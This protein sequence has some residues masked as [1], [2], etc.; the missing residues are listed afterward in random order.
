[1]ISN[2]H[3]IE[4][5]INGK[6]VELESQR[7]LGLRINNVMFDPTKTSTTQAEYSFSFDIPSTPNN[8]KVLEYANNLSKA[9]KF[10]AR[11]PAQVYADGDLI[12]D[13]SL[14][15]QK[16]DSKEGMYTCNL[17]N[18]KINTLDEIFGDMA[19][20]DL[21]WMVDFDGAPTINQVNAS[22][23]TKYF[24]P[25]VCYGAFQKTYIE[26]DE[27]GATYTPKHTFDKYNKWWVQTF[28]PSLNMI[29]QMKIAFE[30]KG[31]SVGG[32]A[33]ADPYINQIYCSTNLAEEQV[34]TYNLGNPK[35]GKV[36]ITV[37]WNNTKS[38]VNKKSNFTGRRNFQNAT[39]AYNQDLTFPYEVVKPA[40]NSNNRDAEPQYNFSEIQWWNM[41]DSTNN[42]SG[43][44]VT[45]NQPTY[46][47]DPNEHLIVIP[48]DGWYKIY[49]SCT[50]T[51]NG[52]GSTFSANQWTN[53]FYEDDEFKER[54]IEVKR[55]FQNNGRTPFEVQL[56]RNYDDNIE[57]IKGKKNVRWDTGNPN[58]ETY[59][60]KGGSYTGSTVI[61][62]HEWKTDAPH[63]DPY[64][65]ISPTIMDNMIN[66]AFGAR[67]DVL[68][69]YG[70]E[71]DL[72]K[73]G[74]SSSADTSGATM[75]G[76]GSIT[77]SGRR[78][79]PITRGGTIDRT[80]GGRNSDYG[81]IRNGGYRG[82]T[83]FN[84]YGFMH[85]D[86]EIMPYDQA[87]STAFICGMSTM[88]DGTLGV[89]RDD[90]SWS[91][92][93]SVRNGVF[94]QV[95]GLDLVNIIDDSGGTETFNT[96]YCKNTYKDSDY[97][98]L[99]SNG[100]MNGHIECCVY[101]N[102]N[103]I[104]E[105]VGVQRAYDSD[106]F[107]SVNATCNLVITAMSDKRKSDLLSDPTWGYRS[108]TQLPTQLNLFNFTNKE[109]K[110][111]DWIKNVQT[112]F[113]F[114]ILQEGNSV[115]INTNKG[116]NKKVDYAVS[117]DD[118]VSEN[119]AIAEYISY[120][121]EMSVRYKINTEEW[122]FE[123]TV[124]EEHIND[125][126]WKEWGDSGFTIIQLNDDTYESKTQNTSTQFSYT[127][128]DNFLWKEVTSSGTETDFSGLTVA[129]PVISKAEYMAEGYGYEEA[130]KHDGYSL[131]QRFWYRDEVSDQY[132][133]LSDHM[134]EQV[135]LTYPINRWE[136]FNLSYKDIEKSIVTEYFNI[137]PLLSSNYVKIDVHLT[138]EEYNSIKCGALVN[139]DSDLYYTSEISGYDPSGDNPTT[140]KLIKKV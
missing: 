118:R 15:V 60:I 88:S 62:K 67:N 58:Q 5:H 94:A 16:Y 1:M 135:Y 70:Y 13:G 103:D 120:P 90:L 21:K 64:A 28:Y 36:D 139:Y 138:P 40:I 33:L 98:L 73:G 49:L 18:I 102:R 137:C 107:Y 134:H 51:L 122:G 48:A 45:V 29:E 86:N 127:Y 72:Y 7:S 57:L 136:R 111:G 115:D 50:A 78:V 133:Y 56:I 35:F 32:S 116:I 37:S 3:Y 59:T 109:T 10:H 69:A 95:K 96:N 112:A 75:D 93:S 41:M 2:T 24:F 46:L 84:T 71:N 121:R 38:A 123:L 91:K 81:T 55:G 132:V 130:M 89:M 129:I 4:L 31:Y 114:E 87:V 110:V 105:L 119:E 22:A 12:F 42:P 66:Q 140:L 79:P 126:D 125:E 6:Q 108:N 99:V 54:E 27:V 52:A 23:D 17:V 34:P 92:M 106:Q 47:Y 25:L 63:Q 26:K 104:L 43:V 128:Y 101:L 76:N 68:L 80:G 117:V 11:Y 44:T 77:N 61:N 85:Q 97:S 20:T 8:N 113:N 30:S 53:T 39:G 83:K 14:T 9:N 65:S 19:M 124:P 100:S 82:A 74:T 131:T